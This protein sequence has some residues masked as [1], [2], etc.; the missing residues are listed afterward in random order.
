MS[1]L[2]NLYTDVAEFRQYVPGISSDLEFDELNGT[3]ISTKNQILSILT[4]DIWEKIIA[5]NGS[6][7]RQS[8]QVAF[9]NLLMY[10]V[11]IFTLIAKRTSKETDF[12]KYELETM[13]RQHIDNYF[14]SMDSIL[15]ELE[16]NE[17]YKLLWNTTTN[18]KLRESLKIKTTDEF[19]SFYNI[20]MSYLFFNRTLFIQ[21]E[22]LDSNIGDYFI[23]IKDREDDFEMKLKRALVLLVISIALTRFDIIEF[24]PTIRSLFDEQKS[25]RNGKEEQNRLLELAGS[26]QNSAMDILKA[27]E[28]ALSEPESGNIVSETSFNRPEDKIYLMA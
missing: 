14:N 1:I 2:T 13:Q 23:R 12:Y 9:G 21:R 19:N 17:D 8:L 4:K 26:L 24:P 5:D 22:V 18:F 3:A 10:K 15:R 27:I 11:L 28:I 6:E 7:I 25:S 20:D 16:E